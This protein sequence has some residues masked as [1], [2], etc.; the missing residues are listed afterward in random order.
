MVG[1]RW[2]GCSVLL[3]LSCG[4][5]ANSDGNAARGGA[6]PAVT[7]G[8]NSGGT[9]SGT[10][11][12][13]G[14][15]SGQAGEAGAP[16]CPVTPAAGQWFA[17]GPDPYGFELS[18]DGSQ[19]SGVGC[20][21]SLPSD[22]TPNSC[23]PL[24]FQ[25]GRGRQVAF[26]WNM[27]DVFF[28]YSVKME[29][30]LAPD[31]TAMAGTVWTSLGS[32][33]EGQDIVLVRYPVEP[34]PPAT[35]CSG[36]EPS[37][38]CFLGPLR[39]DR[40]KEPRVVELGKGDLLLLWKNQRGVGDRIAGTRFDAAA[41]A[42]QEAEFLDDGT[43]P[44]E[45]PIV[46]ASPAGWAMVAYRQNNV[47]LTRAY[48]PMLNVWSEQQVVDIGNDSSSMPHPE[49]LFVY[50][51]GDATL[52]TSV[53]DEQGLRSVSAHEYVAQTRRWE[54]PHLIDVVP[55]TATYEWA[56]A[57]DQA[58]SAVVVW[59]RG[60]LSGA[61]DELWFSIRR[62]GG[63]WS[64]AARLYGSDKQILKP[65]TAVS[66]DGASAIV[67]WQEPLVGIASSSYSFQTY[68]WSEPL[69]VTSEQDADN[70]AVSFNEAGTA[71]AYF[72]RNGALS[73]EAEQKSELAEGAWGPPQTIPVAEAAGQTYSLTRAADGLQVTSLH[74]RAGESTPPPLSLPRCEGY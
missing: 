19:L 73:T 65:A 4:R 57:S 41:G 5:T 69:M 16:D 12:G 58:R 50:D 45:S 40:V 68:A 59:V 27:K 32:S 49:A 14:P 62:A 3:A 66:K 51:G 35:V 10:A 34:V 28:G 48:D 25:A 22:D 54:T 2:V 17:R 64:D 33:D 6:P 13:A 61:P 29:L 42:W 23:S 26:V 38:A 20:L 39:S 56:G 21:G 18:S 24:A 1:F 74:P 31:R 37:G 63:I 72:H 47:L 8:G 30:I 46:T 52:T 67:T 15:V 44:V 53:Q 9:A 55:E 11:S 70:R 71:I 60:G 36:G 43:A 7:G